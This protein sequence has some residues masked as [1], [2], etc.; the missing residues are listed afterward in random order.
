MHVRGAT[1]MQESIP[2]DDAFPQSCKECMLDSVQYWMFTEQ[3]VWAGV[4][5]PVGVSE[6]LLVEWRQ[7]GRRSDS[8]CGA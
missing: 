1:R 6:E 3:K 8:E 7:R 5:C 4:G 2:S